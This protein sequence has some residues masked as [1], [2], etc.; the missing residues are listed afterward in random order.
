MV[1]LESLDTAE[2]RQLGRSR[3]RLE[4]N[5]LDGGD[6]GDHI[7]RNRFHDLPQPDRRAGSRRAAEIRGKIYDE[8]I[9]M[10]VLQPVALRPGEFEPGGLL[11]IDAPGAPE[12]NE[13]RRQGQ[14]TVTMTGRRTE[15]HG[16]TVVAHV[17]SHKRRRTG[18]A[19][20]CPFLGQN[21]D[22]VARTE[23]PTTP[24]IRLIRVFIGVPSLD[25]DIHRAIRV[26]IAAK[27]L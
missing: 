2:I 17:G 3:A 5:L 1:E 26:S 27:A 19:I 24:F 13:C 15:R 4:G 6:I 14:E 10:V 11:G 7:D 25:T 16:R 22:A 18:R 23:S 20:Q 12:Q 8:I 21:D 9:S